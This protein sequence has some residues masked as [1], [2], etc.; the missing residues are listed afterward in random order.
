VLAV[1]HQAPSLFGHAR[2]RWTLALLVGTCLGLA[3]L[4]LSGAW[5][6]LHA[7]GLVAKRS[8]DHVHSPDPAY[9][10]KVAALRA[11]Q[12]QARA[13]PTTH[14]LLYGDEF[15][16]YRQPAPGVAYTAR[17]AGG[18]HQPRAERS[19]RS[20][21]KWRLAGALDALTGQVHWAAASVMGVA[22]LQA[23]LR[24]VRAAYGPTR[25]LTLVW[26]NWPIHTDPRVGATAAAE[27]IALLWLP[28][29]APWLNPIEK[30]WGWLKADVLRLHPW[31]DA[32]DILR[33]RMG[34]FLDQFA[35]G[36]PALLHAVGLAPERSP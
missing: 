15:T 29:Y 19:R 16:A 1:L 20:N 9:R 27:R 6:R 10:E 18:T 7:W 8:R 34:A 26:D 2:T 30:L 31:A 12:A 28:T 5:R 21:T 13:A 25:T 14:T 32:W 3:G 33:T 11:A 24:Q 35:A 36:S 23:F 17:G 22:G 4:S